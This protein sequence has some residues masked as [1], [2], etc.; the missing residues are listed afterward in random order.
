VEIT[1]QVGEFEDIF[2]GLC[3]VPEERK[4]RSTTDKIVF[5]L[6][7]DTAVSNDGL[8]FSSPEPLNVFNSECQDAV[9]DTLHGHTIV[10]KVTKTTDIVLIQI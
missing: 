6:R 7:Y 4:T 3:C 1:P 2:T 9:P 5:S 10:L 8:N